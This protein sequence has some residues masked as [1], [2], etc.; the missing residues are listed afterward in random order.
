AGDINLQGAGQGGGGDFSVTAGGR[1]IVA[2]NVNSSGGS[3]GGDISPQGG[4]LVSSTGNLDA[5]G[6]DFPS[7]GG[8][9]SIDGGGDVTLGGKIL[10]FARG[11]FDGDSA[12]AGEIAVTA[13]G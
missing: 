6:N 10:T 1:L 4:P 3:D 2:G 9:V 5:S 12:D 7:D 11:G 8:A 13:G